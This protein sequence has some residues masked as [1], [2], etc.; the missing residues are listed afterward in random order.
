MLVGEGLEGWRRV[1]G[2]V[3]LNDSQVGDSWRVI[4]LLVCNTERV[5]ESLSLYERGPISCYYHY[6]AQNYYPVYI[7]LIGVLRIW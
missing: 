7:S 5:N 2:M 6:P 3:S 1:E 4:S